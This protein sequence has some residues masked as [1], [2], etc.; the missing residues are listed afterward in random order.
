MNLLEMVQ[1]VADRLGLVRPS[2]VVGATDHQARQFHALANQEGRELARRHAWQAIIKEKTFTTVAQESQTG[3]IPTDFDRIVTGTFYNRTKKRPVSGPLTAQEYADYKGRLASIVHDAFRMRGDAILLLP[4]PSAGWS[5]AYEYASKQ[6]C[7]AASDTAP[8]KEAFAADTDIAFLDAEAMRQG[9]TW[10]FQKSRG[11]DYAE[12]FQQY[13]LHIATLMGR[14]GGNR[15]LSMASMG[16][17]RPYP[18]VPPDG[19]WNLS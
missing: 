6:W 1:E 11:L 12:S 2:Q 17:R 13:E 4:T 14:D 7:G 5:M 16:S 9:V 18:P 10:R 3:A 19:N 15:M 8:T